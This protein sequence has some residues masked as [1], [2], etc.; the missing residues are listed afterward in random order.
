MALQAKEAATAS[1]AVS[2]GTGRG[3]APTLVEVEVMV[4]AAAAGEAAIIMVVGVVTVP[5]AEARTA[6]SAVSL[7][8]GRGTAPTER[9]S[10][11]SLTLYKEKSMREENVNVITTIATL[12]CS[13]SK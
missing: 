11:S 12:S 6:L 3:T 7:G 13:D 5:E 1:S 10:F 2:L 9:L 8:T 4:K